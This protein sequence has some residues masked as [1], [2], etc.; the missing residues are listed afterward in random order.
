MA[1]LNFSHCHW[2]T[3]PGTISMNGTANYDGQPIV[4]EVGGKNGWTL[5]V[6]LMPMKKIICL[7]N[8]WQIGNGQH[9]LIT[10]ITIRIRSMHWIRVLRTDQ[11]MRQI[12]CGDQCWHLWRWSTV[13]EY[14]NIYIIWLVACLWIDENINTY[15]WMLGVG[16]DDFVYL[17]L[18]GNMCWSSFIRHIYPG[19]CTVP[20][21][22]HCN[23]K[24]FLQWG[25]LPMDDGARDVDSTRVSGFGW[26]YFRESMLLLRIEMGTF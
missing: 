10:F 22:D 3:A 16:V 8:V 7:C 24:H 4:R 20:D 17:C 12:R 18:D 26:S 1:Y 14:V 19:P 5:S 9:F 25:A 2:T 6:N 21:D 11:L 13:S 15:K 23:Y